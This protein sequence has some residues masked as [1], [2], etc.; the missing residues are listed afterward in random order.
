MARPVGVWRRGGRGF[1]GEVEWVRV[2][3]W[4]GRWRGIVGIVF[5]KVPFVGGGFVVV[6]SGFLGVDGGVDERRDLEARYGW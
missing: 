4:G 3:F 5:C 1:E 6:W 2:G